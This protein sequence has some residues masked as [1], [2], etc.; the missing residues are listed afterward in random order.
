MRTVT[1]GTSEADVERTINIHRDI[2]SLKGAE[3]SHRTLRNRLQLR[4]SR[5]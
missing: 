5:A 2:A 4:I 1:R 3:Y